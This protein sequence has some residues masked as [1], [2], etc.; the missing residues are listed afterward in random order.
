METRTLKVLILKDLE[1]DT[2][3]LANELRKTG[4]LVSWKQVETEQAYLEEL[5]TGAYQIILTDDPLSS[6]NAR[7]ALQ[8][9]RS[10]K[11]DIPFIV[12]TGNEGAEL[13]VEL[14]RLGASDYLIKDQFVRLGGTVTSALEQKRMR[15]EN[16]QKLHQLTTSEELFR[17]LVENSPDILFRFRLYPEKGFEY[18]G[19]AVEKVT[20]YRPEDFYKDWTCLFRSVHPEDLAGLTARLSAN[21][22]DLNP[23]VLRWVRKDGTVVWTEQRVVPEYNDTGILV[24]V[25]GISRD[26]SELYVTKA[27]QES[28]IAL[29]L[30][31]VI[32][33]WAEALEI[34]GV[35]PP[36]HKNRAVWWTTTLGRAFEIPE[37]QHI[38][39]RRG[40]LLHDIGKLA[41]PEQI[42]LKPG[43]LS[44][45]ELHWIHRHPVFVYEWLSRYEV[46]I[47]SLDIP[48]CHHESWDGNGYPRGLK[49]TEIPLS[50]RIFAVI[51]TW[52]ILRTDR[53]YR[54]AWGRQQAMQY[55]K[56][57]AG[58]RFDPQVVESFILLA[59]QNPE[60]DEM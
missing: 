28:D 2:V 14:M 20:G 54:K 31:G 43:T 18:I 33:S 57:M 49:S 58:I 11:L 52:D 50:A 29:A 5:D 48:Y 22:T 42:L 10:R 30:D 38:H 44:G 12:V 8:L 21:T 59:S 47:P 60:E 41:V 19:P 4:Y 46:L 7:R 39:L 16:W 6:F 36:G 32:E 3:L 37:E 24:A 25:D 26:V 40:A 53:P 51:D 13:A 17:R 15:D 45:E 55:I 34:R 35:E 56:E 1:S 27:K 9:L 23:L